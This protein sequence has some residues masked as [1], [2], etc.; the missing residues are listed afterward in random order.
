LAGQKNSSNQHP[1]SARLNTLITFDHSKRTKIN[2]TH[3]DKP[4]ASKL[5][6]SMDKSYN[7]E[8]LLI[9]L[10][11]VDHYFSPPLSSKVNLEEYVEKI[12][13][14]AKL[15][16]RY[17]KDREIIGLTVLYCNDTK[18]LKAYVSLVA[19]AKDHRSRGYARDMMQEVLGYVR[20]TDFQVV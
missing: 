9:F 2:I 6:G 8:K 12:A 15:V 11:Q 17:S 4:K 16:I 10:L 14:Q 5:I 20:S 19:V 3:I 18:D 13:H 7:K 1:H